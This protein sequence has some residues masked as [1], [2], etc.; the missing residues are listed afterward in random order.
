MKTKFSTVTFLA[1][2]LSLLTVF[3]ARADES[4]IGRFDSYFVSQLTNF[5][6]APALEAFATDQGQVAVDLERSQVL[7]SLDSQRGRFE[8]ALPVVSRERDVC[9]VVTYRGTDGVTSLEI[10]DYSRTTCIRANV[11]FKRLVLTVAYLTTVDEQGVAAVS[12]FEGA[13]LLSE[14]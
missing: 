4:S 2:A 3:T 12:A 6:L 1:V 11:G 9:N 7:I 8:I 13:A 14:K 10:R 5:R